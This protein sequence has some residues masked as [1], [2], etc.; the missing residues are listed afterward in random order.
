MQNAQTLEHCKL[1]I[2]SGFKAS[3][4]QSQVGPT[5]VVD[6]IF[7]FMS[8]VSCLERIREIGFDNRLQ[9]SEFE[10]RCRNE[11][12]DSSIIANWGN[13]RQYIVSDI[14]FDSNPVQMKFDHNGVKTS[15]ADYFLQTYKLRISDPN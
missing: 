15:I 3:V 13:Q 4:F 11:F 7:K 8:T 6:S 1:K 14:I 5:L 12:V 2:M 10:Q 9:R